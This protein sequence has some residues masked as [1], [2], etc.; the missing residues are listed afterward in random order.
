MDIIYPKHTQEKVNN[1]ATEALARETQISSSFK[2]YIEML[3][4]FL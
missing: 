4:R 1:I 3:V 2:Y